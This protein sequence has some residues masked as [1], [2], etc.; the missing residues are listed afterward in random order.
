MMM[1]MPLQTCH[2]TR[3]QHD[4]FSVSFAGCKLALCSNTFHLLLLL[5]LSVFLFNGWS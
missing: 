1:M 2:L 3:N 5:L 4:S